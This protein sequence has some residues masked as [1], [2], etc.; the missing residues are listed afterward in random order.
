MG[1]VKTIVLG[2]LALFFG[3]YAMAL[4]LKG[5]KNSDQ[6]LMATLFGLLAYWSW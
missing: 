6:I 2:V 4:E 5:I 3:I 1:K